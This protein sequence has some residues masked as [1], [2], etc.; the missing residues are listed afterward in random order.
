MRRDAIS[1][2]FL[3]QAA[4]A[5]ETGLRTELDALQAKHNALI[6]AIDLFKSQV[7]SIGDLSAATSTDG[8]ISQLQQEKRLLSDQVVLVCNAFAHSSV[9]LR[10]TTET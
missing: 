10:L 3:S 9:D 5:R 6:A 8:R 4:A 7:G 2:Y 1:V